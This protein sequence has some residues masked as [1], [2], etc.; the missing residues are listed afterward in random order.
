MKKKKSNNHPTLVGTSKPPTKNQHN[1]RSISTNGHPKPIYVLER[2][3]S[4]LSIW[5]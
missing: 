3:S 2:A 4:I 1:Q 5:P